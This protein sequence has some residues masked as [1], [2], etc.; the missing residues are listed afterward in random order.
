M[1][2]DDSEKGRY[3]KDDWQMDLELS[4]E[5]ILILK[6]KNVA[7]AKVPVKTIKALLEKQL[8]KELSTTELTAQ[9]QQY[10]ASLDVDAEF[11]VYY[12]SWYHYGA[13]ADGNRGE[14]RR[15]LEDLDPDNLE[16]NKIELRLIN[17]DGDV[18][19]GDD[20]FIDLSDSP[21]LIDA[22]VSDI[23]SDLSAYI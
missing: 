2:Y 5:E 20:S 19:G 13:D 6:E 23:N 16:I 3:S 18:L 22:I 21:E 11:Y 10:T 4:G 7:L 1:S 15:D 17:E 12:G 9:L 14:D 8:G